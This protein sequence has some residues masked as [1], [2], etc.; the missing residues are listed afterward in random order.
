MK[1]YPK[2]ILDQ[3]KVYFV[4]KNSCWVIQLSPAQ[5]LHFIERTDNSP[6]TVSR[7]EFAMATYMFKTHADHMVD[8]LRTLWSVQ[9]PDGW[10]PNASIQIQVDTSQEVVERTN[11]LLKHKAQVPQ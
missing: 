8:Y 1:T 7:P 4:E 3:I 6:V 5:F 9:W 10:D 2:E 11:W